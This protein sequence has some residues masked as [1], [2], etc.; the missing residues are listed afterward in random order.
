[1]ANYAHPKRQNMPGFESLT[2]TL[3]AWIAVVML[4][5]GVVQGALGLGFPTVATPLIALATDIRTAV[6][7]VLLPCIATVLVSVVRSGFLR[8]ALCSSSG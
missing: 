1:M 7:L 3:I 8:E 2:L 6:I 5:A 4:L